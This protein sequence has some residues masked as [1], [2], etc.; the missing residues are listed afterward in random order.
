MRRALELRKRR[1]I[2]LVALAAVAGLAAGV[3]YACPAPSIGSKPPVLTRSRDARFSFADARIGVTFVCSLDGSAYQRCASPTTY[4]GLAAGRHTFSVK[5]ENSFGGTSV[6]TSYSW[7]IDRK[8]PSIEIVFPRNRWVYS[9]RGWSAGCGRHR[10]GVC[11]TA[12]DPVG[13][14]FVVVSIKQNVTG[15]YW[16]GRRFHARKEVYLRARLSPRVLRGRP[17]ASRNWFY[18]IRLPSP[19]GR[20]TLHVRGKDELG[21]IPRRRASARSGFTIDTRRPAVVITSYP[22]DPSTS[23]TARFTFQAN[24]AKVRFRCR[25][26]AQPWSPCASPIFYSELSQSIHTFTVVA[27]DAA[28]N[29]SASRYSWRIVSSLPLNL[30]GDL[31]TSAGMLY[32]GL[33]PQHLPVTL[34]NPNAVTIY[35]T[36][37]TAQ[38]QSTG[39]PGCSA[40]WFM[41]SQARIPAKGIAVPPHGSVT[42]PAQGATA[43][44]IGL[45]ESGTNQDPCQG[46]RLTLAYDGSAHG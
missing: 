22:S 43:P 26:D 12:T 39:A 32:P 35:V 41:I 30:R 31:A 25:L 9:R 33:A 14:A 21:N 36:E 37:V 2:W 28:G 19:D 29:A 7:R 11:G 17:S 6:S 46:A 8:P 18:P 45:I 27:I 1:V 5:A 24:E 40:E 38:L 34:S 23:R 16:N 10:P 44:T 20:Y 13:L 3:A 42:L 4:V 15:R